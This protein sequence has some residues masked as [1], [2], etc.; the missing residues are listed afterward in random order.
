MS[1]LKMDNII[2][3][4]QIREVLKDK[5]ILLCF[6]DELITMCERKE[7]VLTIEDINE[8]DEDISLDSCSDSDEE[9]WD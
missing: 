9:R 8:F 5:G 7:V 1:D 2:E 4:K 6:F 3:V